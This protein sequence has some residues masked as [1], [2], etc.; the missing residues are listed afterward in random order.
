MGASKAVVDVASIDKKVTGSSIN[1]ASTK[2][3][4]KELKEIASGGDG[5]WAHSGEGVHVF[6]APDNLQFWRALIEGPQ[7]SPFEGGVFALNVIVPDDYPF[8]PP[9]ITFETPIYHCNVSDSGKIC[10]NILHDAWNP[11][12]SVPKCLEAIRIM[13]KS[14]D[15]DNALR[16]WIADL[17]LAHFK[18]VNTNTPDERYYDNGKEHTKQHASTTV[19]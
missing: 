6:P 3:L 14:P 19:E 2:R 4:L 7:G 5:I 8:R 16:Q 17:T 9:C 12:L 10:L 15:T 11:S 1:S 13:M 18:Y